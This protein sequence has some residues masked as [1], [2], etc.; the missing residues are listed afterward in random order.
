MS[1]PAIAV[2]QKNE[3]DTFKLIL[4]FL[5]QIEHLILDPTISE[6][7]INSSTDIFIERDGVMSRVEGVTIPRKPSSPQSKISPAISA[8]TSQN[9][10][11]SSI[12]A[13][14]TAAESPPS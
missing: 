8:T 7:M 6:I 11:P 9:K 10:N 13:S 1:A 4:P 12:P 14:A 5:R 3:R 2:D